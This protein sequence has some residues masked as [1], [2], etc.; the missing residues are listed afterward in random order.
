MLCSG[1]INSRTEFQEKNIFNHVYVKSAN[2]TVSTVK[3]YPIGKILVVLN[4]N[5]TN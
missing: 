3:L 5:S 1:L 4:V 2:V